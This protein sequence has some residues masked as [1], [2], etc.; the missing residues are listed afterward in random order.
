MPT[1]QFDPARSRAF[2]LRALRDYAQT[3]EDAKTPTEPEIIPVV[4]PGTETGGFVLWTVG[5]FLLFAALA[6]SVGGLLR[7]WVG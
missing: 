2:A 5:A 7:L 4:W 1:P 6:F 3:V